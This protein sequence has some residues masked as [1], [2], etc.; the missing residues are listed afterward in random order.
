MG[1]RL[2]DRRRAD[3]LGAPFAKRA[4]GGGEG[5]LDDL[6]RVATAHRLKNRIVF[7]IHRQDARAGAARRRHDGVA[8]ADQRF[9]VGQRDRSSRGDRLVGRGEAGR[10]DNR[11]DDHL[12]LTH[13]RLDD[14]LGA[15][16]DFN[17]LPRDFVLQFGV[18]RWSAI[19]ANRAFRASAVLARAAPSRPPATAITSNR[20]GAPAM[21]CA[22]ER[23]TEPVAPRMTTRLGAACSSLASSNGSPLKNPERHIGE[24]VTRGPHHG[25]QDRGRGEAVQP[26]H[27]AAMTGDRD[28]SNRLTPNRRLSADSNRSPPCDDDFGGEAETKQ[29]GDRTAA[30]ATTSPAAPPQATP[31]PKPDHVFAGES[32]GQ[33]FGPPMSR[34]PK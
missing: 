13:R 20:P 31:T 14:G 29:R 3:S 12:G 23:P 32:R 16:C 6:R 15:G 11:G 33:S 8:R 5:H 30:G 34:P 24:S 19:A 1:E 26:V 28:G 17:A 27:Q 18:A 9:L 7:G 21:T 2:A 10:A 4:A 22:Q 25:G